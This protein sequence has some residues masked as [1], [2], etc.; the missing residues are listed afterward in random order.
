VGQGDDK[1]WEKANMNGNRIVSV[2]ITEKKWCHCKDHS[3]SYYISVEEKFRREA[4]KQQIGNGQRFQ[5][6]RE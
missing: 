6:A 3:I 5:E 1:V 2:S 4:T